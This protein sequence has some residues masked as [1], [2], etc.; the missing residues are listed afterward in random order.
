MFFPQEGMRV[1]RVVALRKAIDALPYSSRGSCCPHIPLFGSLALAGWSTFMAFQQ[2]AL[3]GAA[4]RGVVGHWIVI[5][6]PQAPL[7]ARFSA[8]NKRRVASRD[9]YIQKHTW[10]A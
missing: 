8:Q 2:Q 6:R 7:G 5:A 3:C 9:I 10:I 4:S 1:F